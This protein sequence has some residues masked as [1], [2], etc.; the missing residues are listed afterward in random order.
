MTGSDERF[1]SWRVQ[2]FT[3]IHSTAS[4]QSQVA[5]LHLFARELLAFLVSGNHD[6]S[7]SWHREAALPWLLL[8]GSPT[9]HTSADAGGRDFSLLQRSASVRCGAIAIIARAPSD[10]NTCDTL[11]TR[12]DDAGV[13]TARH[14]R[15]VS[16]SAEGSSAYRDYF[17]CPKSPPAF[18]GKN[19]ERGKPAQGEIGRSIQRYR[20]HRGAHASRNQC[21]RFT[22]DALGGPTSQVAWQIAADRSTV[23]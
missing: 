17:Y 6:A 1:A 5:T 7:V 15:G 23:T 10:R 16:A 13:T 9:A 2:S 3:V 18:E 14:K 22:R 8:S 20:P 11:A 12:L 21:G 19:P 4:A